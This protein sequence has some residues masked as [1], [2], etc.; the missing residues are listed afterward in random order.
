MAHHNPNGTVEE[1]YEELVKAAGLYGK[2]FFGERT[3]RKE[4]KK[5]QSL[6]K[7]ALRTV[8]ARNENR[9]KIV[10]KIAEIKPSYGMIPGSTAYT[11]E[12]LEQLNS[13]VGDAAD[14]DPGEQ[15][16]A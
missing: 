10:E 12:E 8:D 13:L 5:L 14:N 1:V 6:W 15:N 3:T 11:P 4:A 2:A 9:A 7:L 16:E